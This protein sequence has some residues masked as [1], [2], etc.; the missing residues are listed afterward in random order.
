MENKNKRT[1]N[2]ILKISIIVVAIVGII[3]QQL[4]GLL[5]YT[6]HVPFMYFTTQSNIFI[7]LCMGLLLYYDFAKK[8]VPTGH[9][10]TPLSDYLAD[11]K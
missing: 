3:S 10:V 1:I 11:F 9:N 2:I 5:I 6:G 8:P 7:A 4:H